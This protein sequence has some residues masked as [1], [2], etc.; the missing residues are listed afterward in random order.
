LKKAIVSIVIGKQ[1][2]ACEQRWVRG[3]GN[4]RYEVLA[5]KH[6]LLLQVVQFNYQS[7]TK[8]FR[9]IGPALWN[10][11]LFRESI[12][13]SNPCDHQQID[14]HSLLSTLPITLVKLLP[15]CGFWPKWSQCWV[16]I[17]Y[18]MA[19][20]KFHVAANYQT[21]LKRFKEKHHRMRW[22][23]LPGWWFVKD[24]RSPF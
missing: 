19:I 12:P 13:H 5:D 8:G 20:N 9:T 11:T 16:A 24:F 17:S 2:A 14:G 4:V 3:H 18:H 23:F 1:Y 15:V 6:Q 7:I 22:R 10:F 21:I